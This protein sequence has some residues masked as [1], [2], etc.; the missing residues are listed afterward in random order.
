MN[1]Y[2]IGLQ[3]KSQVAMARS[4]GHIPEGRVFFV[5]GSVS[6]KERGQLLLVIF[7]LVFQHPF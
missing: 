4:G 2:P 5:Q 7:L 6:G 1:S 3:G